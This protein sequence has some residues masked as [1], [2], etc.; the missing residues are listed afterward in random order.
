MSRDIPILYMKLG[1]KHVQCFLWVLGHRQHP[2]HQVAHGVQGSQENQHYQQLPA[3]GSTE[4]TLINTRRSLQRA[5][6]YY[7]YC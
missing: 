1:C 6:E 3:E 5:K 2:E 7:V 4:S